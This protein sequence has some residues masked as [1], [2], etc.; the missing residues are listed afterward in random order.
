[1]QDYTK[2]T[3]IAERYGYHLDETL[4]TAQ[5]EGIIYQY[6]YTPKE[7]KSVLRMT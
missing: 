5:N 1:M 4:A 3:V 6:N 2:G 7:V